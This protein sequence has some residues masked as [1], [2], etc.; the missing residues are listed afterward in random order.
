L[1]WDSIAAFFSP[2]VPAWNHE[3]SKRQVR[4]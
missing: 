3:I 1:S 2:V 4:R